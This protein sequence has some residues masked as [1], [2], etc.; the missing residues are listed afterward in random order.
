MKDYNNAILYYYD[1]LKRK[2]TLINQAHRVISLYESA[3]SGMS[4]YI[5][6]S[7]AKFDM[8]L[9]IVSILLSIQVQIFC[10]INFS[11]FFFL[12]ILNYFK[13]LFC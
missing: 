4:N 12:I 3:L 1:W 6:G 10:L 9:I 7:I 8:F 13:F 2:T 11:S 5:I